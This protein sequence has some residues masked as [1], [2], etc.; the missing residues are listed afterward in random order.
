MK[1]IKRWSTCLISGFDSVISKVENH[2]AVVDNSIRDLQKAAAAAMVKLNRLRGEISSMRS[3][4]AALK[5]NNERWSHRALQLRDSD[6]EKAI[7]CLRRRKRGEADIARLES[8]IPEHEAIANQIAADLSRFETR[9]SE[10]KLKKRSFSSRA[11][12]AKALQICEAT[13]SEAE[14]EDLN[15]VFDRWEMKLATAEIGSNYHSDSL[16]E[17][18][19][20]DE[21]N[22]ALAAE[23]ESLSSDENTTK[24]D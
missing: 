2:E 7:E 3:K 14:S 5:A 22:D 10:L 8:D 21:E 1:K 9:I 6:K 13:N 16:E 20:R 23:L 12:R 24:N 19:L 15:D 4:V 17:E 18:F 11:S